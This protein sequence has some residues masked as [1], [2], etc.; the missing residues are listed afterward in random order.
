MES[1]GGIF[2]KNGILRKYLEYSPDSVLIKEYAY[3]KHSNLIMYKEIES[4]CSIKYEYQ[5]EYDK[6][7]NIIKQITY[8]NGVPTL[9]SIR[10]IEYFE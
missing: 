1:Y 4:Y 5:N 7:G 9:I 2:L 6:K 10:T 8:D 3:D